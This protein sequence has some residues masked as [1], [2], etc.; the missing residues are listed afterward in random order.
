MIQCIVMDMDG[1]ALNSEQKITPLTHQA[2]LKAQENGVR[3]ILASGRSITTLMPFAK[4]LNMETYVGALVGANGA[5]ITDVASNKTE[6]I[7]QCTIAQQAELLQFAQNHDCEFMAVLNQTIYHY[8]PQSLVE[9]KLAYKKAHQ[10]ADDVPLTAGTFNLVVD[11]RKNYSSII[12]IFSSNDLKEASNKICLSATQAHI[13]TIEPILIQQF[14]H[15]YNI[16]KTGPAWIECGPL[17]VHKGAA[18]SKILNSWN[19]NPTNCVVFGDA[20]NDL[21]MLALTPYSVAMGN[22]MESVKKACHYVTTSNND[23]GIAQA[24]T[25][26]ANDHL[27]FLK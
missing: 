27:L 12:P 22:A 19:I 24:I 26:F 15:L 14:A 18:V 23:D 21:S 7:A 4:S 9:P 11:Q 13:E 6:V 17:G 8:L 16:S 10:I 3:L 2:L 5:T 25:Q 1:T 20:E